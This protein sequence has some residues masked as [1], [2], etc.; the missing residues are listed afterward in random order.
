MC[1]VDVRAYFFVYVN[2]GEC[3]RNEQSYSMRPAYT[4]SE[5]RDGTLH[6]TLAQNMT[7]RSSKGG[8]EPLRGYDCA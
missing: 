7:E 5:R 8:F 2:D 6:T 4:A 1:I 3:Q